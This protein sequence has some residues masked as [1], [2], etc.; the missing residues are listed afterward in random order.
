MAHLERR[1]Q[2]T[3]LV[4]TPE[5]LAKLGVKRGDAVEM[6]PEP[7]RIIIEPKRAGKRLPA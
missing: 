4:L 5:N 7:G 1:R 2:S 6:T 3:Y